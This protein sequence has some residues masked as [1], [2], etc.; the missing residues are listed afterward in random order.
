MKYIIGLGNPEAQYE[1][2]R[3][4]VGREIVTKFA[5]K[6]D[7]KDFEYD[8]KINAQVS[9]GKI[10]KEQVTLILPDT[11]MN[12][13][14]NAVKKLI[15]SAKK[16]EQMTV[17]YDDLDLGLGNLKISFNKSDGGHN[18]L[19]SIIRAVKTEKF[20][21]LR[22]G[23]STEL[24]SG[25]IKKPKGEEAVVKHVLGKFSP[26]EQLVLKKVIVRAINGL[27]LV[28]RENYLIASNPVNSGK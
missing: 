9:V 2:S 14:G 22:V 21:R 12:N 10:G 18:G 8:K 17:V 23:I 26:K 13:S 5:K 27:E 7:F 20:P 11:Y 19:A 6:F 4:N 25:K 15:T 28:V 3:H 16:A 1:G 24:A